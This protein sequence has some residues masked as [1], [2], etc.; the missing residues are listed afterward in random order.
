MRSMVLISLVL[1]FSSPIKGDDF[2]TQQLSELVSRGQLLCASA[3]LYFNPD[4]RTPDPRSLTAVYHHLN[5]LDTYVLQLGHPPQLLQPLRAM[6]RTFGELDALPRQQ[7][8]RNSALL[9]QLL[10]QQRLLQLAASA[11]YRKA[12]AGAGP[13]VSLQLLN[14]Q[15]QE[16][17]ALL[18]DYQLRHS[19]SVN[20]SS[21]LLDGERLLAL[22]QAIEKRFDDMQSAIAEHAAVLGRVRSQYQFVRP[23]LQVRSGRA[24]GGAE[25]YLSRAVLDL[26]ELAM[27]ILL[28]TP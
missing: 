9:E 26:D 12:R 3:L 8:R 17:A 20:G 16:M 15:S 2:G 5:T 25:F 24:H 28:G 19:P 13:A 4:E 1:M 14:G 7:R 18:L 22:D 27:T 11:A 23:L 6:Q 10:T 21:W